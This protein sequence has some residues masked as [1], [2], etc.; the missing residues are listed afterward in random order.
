M[1][2]HADES[3]GK[4]V[5]QTFL[6]TY[7]IKT[8]NDIV[9]SYGKDI[10][11]IGI[12]IF[13]GKKCEKNLIFNG[14]QIPVFYANLKEKIKGDILASYDDGLPA[15]SYNK[16][17]NKIYLNSDIIKTSFLML[18]RAEEENT[19]KDELGRFQ[20]KFSM[21]KN[22]EYP[23]VNEY[24]ELLLNLLKIIFENNGKSIKTRKYWPEDAPYAVCLTHDV[25]N[26]Y[27]WWLK[28][29]VS[30]V[31]KQRKIREVCTSI[32]KKEYWNF[33]KII[34]LEEKYGFRST[35]FFLTTK[36]D[37]QPRYNIKKLKGLISVLNENGWEI[38]L[39]TGLN[40]YDDYNKML[41]EKRK[42]EKVLEEKISGLRNHFIR[43]D[44][45]E[46]WQIQEKSGFS[47]DTTLGFR[48]TVGFRAGF[49]HP[50]LPYD[51]K[52]DESFKILELPMTFMDN[53][54]FSSEDPYKT[55]D[56]LIEMVKKFNGLLVV[57][58]HQSVFDEKDYPNH[59]RMYE[60][61][62]KRFKRDKAFVSTCYN[63]A[64]WWECN[65]IQTIEGREVLDDIQMIFTS[66]AGRSGTGY[67]ANLINKNATNATAEHDPYP[68]GYGEPIKW[69]DNKEDE[70]L[71]KLAKS[72]IKRLAKS[73]IKRLER[74]N[75]LL[76]N[77]AYQEKFNINFYPCRKF[78]EGLK[79]RIPKVEIKDIYLESTHA[80]TKSFGDAM[81]TLIP[82]ISLVH[83]TRNPLEVAKSFFN[84][85]SIPGPTNIYLLDPHFKRNEIKLSID[86]TDFQKCLW[87]W[88][89]TEMRHVTFIEKHDIK[90]IYEIDIEELNDKQ[91]VAEMFKTFGITHKNLLLDVDR[92]KNKKPTILTK[93]D[94]KE[95]RELIEVIP[96]RV[97]D[98]MKNT[99]NVE[100]MI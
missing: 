14:K 75:K 17:L 63:L 25:D 42:L 57:N 53:T 27:K 33:D 9:F 59:I 40:S 79:S 99:Y 2:I 76:R 88:F 38:G 93:Q 5:F 46:T 20:A 86:M 29:I 34:D 96:N 62:L 48:E 89:E 50:F 56:K 13:K 18:S 30:Y 4:Y 77:I 95:A 6:S 39:H 72:K 36:R 67:L 81:C 7:G 85:G 32:G 90:K 73:K 11:E 94:L 28:K 98:K 47:Y 84:R 87:Y 71:L 19:P 44:V 69:Y 31:V 66:T 52:N 41:K 21:N 65:N 1:K 49:C 22:V 60:S 10:N 58:W 78:F 15:I 37:T 8:E 92:N 97:F 83:L 3:W 16:E 70:K 55:L 61:M 68:R 12:T 100:E 43:F 74:K 24:F 54:I 45:P 80:F 51:F 23:L 26:V 64:K 35:F 91:K 82:N